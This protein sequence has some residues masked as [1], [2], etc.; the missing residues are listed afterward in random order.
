MLLA[1]C[2]GF[3]PPPAEPSVPIEYPI[4]HYRFTTISSDLIEWRREVRH[5]R[6]ELRKLYPAD[7]NARPAD[8]WSSKEVEF[9]DRA[10]DPSRIIWRDPSA[11]WRDPA[12]LSWWELIDETGRIQKVLVVTSNRSPEE[13][14]RIIAWCL[15]GKSWTPATL[16]GE[17]TRSVRTA[18]INLGTSRWHISYWQR[19]VSGETVAVVAIILI[20]LV[21]GGG[22]RLVRRVRKPTQTGR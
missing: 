3:E 18:S 4:V 17:A 1:G 21:V 16:D 9:L 19:K 10:V 2:G 7:E 11:F 14:A 20:A 6:G 5:L 13:D 15:R 22:V 8:E 12:I